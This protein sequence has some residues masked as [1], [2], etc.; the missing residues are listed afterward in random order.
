M[1]DK[2]NKLIRC[3]LLQIKSKSKANRDEYR[4]SKLTVKRD[5]RQHQEGVDED[6]GRLLRNLRENKKLFWREVNKV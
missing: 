3:R 5:I 4:R 6:W 1:S 2:L